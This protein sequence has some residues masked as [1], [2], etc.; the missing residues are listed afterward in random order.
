MIIDI[1]TLTLLRRANK[2]QGALGNY[3]RASHRKEIRFF[4]QTF[5]NSITYCLMLVSFHVIARIVPP[6]GISVVLATTTAWELAHAG[7]G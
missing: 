2:R 6:T 3:M 5:A 1:A 4:F 7:G